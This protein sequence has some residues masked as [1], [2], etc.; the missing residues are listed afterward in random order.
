MLCNDMSLYT[1]EHLAHN[2][3]LCIL[4]GINNNAA[5]PRR[6]DKRVDPQSSIRTPMVKEN[7]PVYMSELYNKIT[8]IETT[9]KDSKQRA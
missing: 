6:A 9:C 2:N 1:R 7:T 8:L 5:A 4:C 3:I